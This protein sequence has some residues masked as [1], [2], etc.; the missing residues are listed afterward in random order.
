[1]EIFISVVRILTM[2]SILYTFFRINK[3][4]E[5]QAE[6]NKLQSDI[7]EHQLEWNNIVNEKLKRLEKKN[8]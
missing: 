7:H 8:E 3:L 2:A 5:S 1:M 6:L 4:L